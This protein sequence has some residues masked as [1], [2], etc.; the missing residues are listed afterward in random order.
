M[1][2]GIVRAGAGTIDPIRDKAKRN[3]LWGAARIRGELLKLGT[4][5][6]K[7]TIQKYTRLVCIRRGLA[8]PPSV[9]PTHVVG[10]GLELAAVQIDRE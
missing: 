6:S 8:G 2:R 4:K 9:V 1:V 5:V 10:A 3:R 7:R